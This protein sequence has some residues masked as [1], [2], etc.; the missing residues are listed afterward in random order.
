MK[1]QLSCPSFLLFYQLLLTRSSFQQ[2][3]VCV[4]AILI[5]DFEF[6]LRYFVI[7]TP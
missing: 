2:N 6:N 1:P 5:F 4:H 7:Y 3:K